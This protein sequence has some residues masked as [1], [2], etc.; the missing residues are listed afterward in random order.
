MGRLSALTRL[1]RLLTQAELERVAGSLEVDGSP[2]RAGREV[3]THLRSDA[4]SLLRSLLH[5]INDPGLA[6][7][8]LT[9]AS[10]IVDVDMPMIEPVWSGPALP[11]DSHRTTGAVARLIDEASESVWATTYSSAPTAP[12][13]Q[14]LKRA[15]A[16][17][18]DVTVVADVVNLPD[19]ATML[20]RE[21]PSATVLGY[22]HEIDGRS[23][24]QHS[25]VVIIDTETVLVTSAN[26]S[27]AAVEVN[28][29]AGLIT[30]DPTL[31]SR[32]RQHFVDLWMADHLRPVL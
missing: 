8:M 15:L 7:A 13:V 25:K 27:T 12:F 31:A 17:G 9:S 23:G 5:E 29:E 19:T 22:Q 28:L 11:G 10:E 21:L 6:A 1:A 20:V 14:A 2:S 18:I 30:K 3:R 4:T 26:L 24:L 16:R 32:I